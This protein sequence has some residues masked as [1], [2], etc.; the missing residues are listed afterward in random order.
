MSGNFISPLVFQ[1]RLG[2]KGI[3]LHIETVYRWC[4]AGDLD[5]RIVG[6]SWKIRESEVDRV[7]EDG[8][9]RPAAASVA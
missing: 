3:D 5:A 1:Q 6:R 8:T 9:D 2:R 7:A 4:R